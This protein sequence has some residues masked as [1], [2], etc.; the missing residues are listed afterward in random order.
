MKLLNYFILFSICGLC[1]C[2]NSSPI[3]YLEKS[4]KEVAKLCVT[5]PRFTHPINGKKNQIMIEV[6]HGFCYY[7]SVNQM[8]E[9]EVVMK[10]NK[11]RINFRED[12][13]KLYLRLA[14]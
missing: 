1:S 4:K 7:D 6:N 13:K 12:R 5:Y 11:W 3:N 9:D 10:A 8:L 2:S 14:G